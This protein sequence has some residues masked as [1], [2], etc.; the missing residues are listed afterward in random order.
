MN[1]VKVTPGKVFLGSLIAWL[2]LQWA[3]EKEREGKS[4]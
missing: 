3:K 4:K 2:L 1:M